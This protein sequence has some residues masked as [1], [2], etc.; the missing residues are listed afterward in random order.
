MCKFTHIFFHLR[1][2]IAPFTLI[3]VVNFAECLVHSFTDSYF[4]L[5]FMSIDMITATEN[6]RLS[7]AVALTDG[8]GGNYKDYLFT[9]RSPVYSGPLS[10]D[11]DRIR[12]PLM[13]S[14]R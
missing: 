2:I 8:R 14:A 9:W 12:S 3:G 13:S 6:S 1:D 5:I 7:G 10:I 11:S 4:K